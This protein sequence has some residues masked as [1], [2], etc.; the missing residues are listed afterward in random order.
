MFVDLRSAVSRGIF[1]RGEFDPTVF[2]PLRSALK[3]GGTFLDVGANVGYYSVLALDAVG[4]TGAIHAFEVDERP[5]RCL[6]KTVLKEMINNLHLHETAV[7]DRDGTVGFRMHEDS[8]NSGLAEAGSSRLVKMTTLD[9]WWRNSGVKNIQAIKLDVEGA[10][11]LALQG[12]AQMMM[13]TRP[14]VVCEADES[15]QAPFGYGQKHL[16]EHLAALQYRVAPLP[17]AWSPTMVA[18]PC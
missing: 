4:P 14:L 3:Q 11:L 1:A 12:G 6:R 17:G 15:L 13:S 7:G 5:L 2:E 18:V 10:E 9:T 16:L 8:G